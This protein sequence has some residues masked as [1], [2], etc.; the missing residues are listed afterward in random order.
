MRLPVRPAI[1]L[2]TIND[3]YKENGDW[4]ICL[5]HHRQEL[6][7]TPV[8]SNANKSLNGHKNIPWK[9]FS[10]WRHLGW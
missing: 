8:F 3:I 6:M 9:T 10:T 1:A 7:D 5:L 2:N 4:H